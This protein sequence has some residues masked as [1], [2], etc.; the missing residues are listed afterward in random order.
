[1][2]SKT[3]CER[4]NHQN[5]ARFYSIAFVLAVI[6]FSSIIV[7]WSDLNHSAETFFGFRSV[8]FAAEPKNAEKSTGGNSQSRTSAKPERKQ[9][10]SDD[11]ESLGQEDTN[12][13]SVDEEKE[14]SLLMGNSLDAWEP[15]PK[16]EKSKWTLKDGVLRLNGKGPSLVTKQK[17][18]DFELHLEF[19]LPS[20]C[21][22]GVYLRGRYEISLL[23]SDFRNKHGQPV[24]PI[25]ACGAIWGKI[26]PAIDAYK[27]PN[28]WNTLDVRLVGQ[29]VTV[30]L[31][32]SLIID[33]RTIR[34]VTGGALDANETDPGPILLQSS[35]V[36]GSEFRSLRIKP[37]PR[38]TD[39]SESASRSGSNGPD[40]SKHDSRFV[41]PKG[42]CLVMIGQD[43]PAIDEYIQ[44]IGRIPAGVMT[45]DHI[46]S[47]VLA[48]ASKYRKAYP[49]AAIQIGLS[50]KDAIDDVPKGRFDSNIEKLADWAN[51]NPVPIYL[52]PGY[53]CDL[54][55]NQYPSDV[56]VRA[57]RHIRKTLDQYEVKNIAMVWHVLPGDQPIEKWWP[58]DR[59]VDWVGLTYF[60]AQQENMAPIAAFA[61][62]HA[63]PLMLAEAA[64]RG[65]GTLKGKQ[66][67]D[68]WFRPCF[69]DIA[70]YDVRAFCYI[71]WDWQSKEMFRDGTWGD[72]RIERNAFVKTEWIK[73]V[74]KGK[75]AVS[76]EDLL[77]S[78]GRR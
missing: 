76:V 17:F 27:G 60:A 64:P 40:N 8:L 71:N 46:T 24:G 39:E 34:G 66:S 26:A 70:Q 4:K 15:S 48:E 21:N 67:W 56:F 19:K 74:S 65:I 32:D 68:E 29:E 1:M 12:S 33:R 72:T 73:E 55:D 20:K 13:S 57:F 61:K 52:R 41:P 78:D 18:D 28:K 31:N 69:E 16:S 47:L 35:D 53:E 30:R 59:Y 75:Y 37:I 54:P 7:S 36:I 63:K 3:L 44:E 77:R 9:S 62:R 23:D 2:A 58:G 51:Q 10:D 49:K 45:Y 6:A 43:K 38:D 14:I 25:G 50:L 42:K 5:S 22:S 11:R